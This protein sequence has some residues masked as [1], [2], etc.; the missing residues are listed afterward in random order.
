MRRRPALHVHE[1]KTHPEPFMAL[2]CLRKWHEV[3][4]N[5]RDFQVGDVLVLREY[6]PTKG[7]NVGEVRG[8]SGNECYRVI[9]Y[10][11][12]GGTWG[13]PPDLCVLSLQ[14]FPVRP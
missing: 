6:D 11:S 7:P 8:Y 3:R 13:L 4:R 9:T 14:V 1:L 10:I 5:D 12:E 2:A